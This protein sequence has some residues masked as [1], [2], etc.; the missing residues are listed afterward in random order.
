MKEEIQLRCK[1]ASC[2]RRREP[3][4]T[5]KACPSCG[6]PFADQ[7]GRTEYHLKWTDDDGKR[8]YES[9]PA[10]HKTL[11][12]ARKA[13]GR[14]IESLEDGTKSKAA[15]TR[16]S[17]LIEIYREEIVPGM[18]ANMKNVI[19]HLP[20]WKREIGHL[21]LSQVTRKVLIDA[22]DKIVSDG[23]YN[24][25][26]NR[27]RNS[28]SGVFRFA[29]RQDLLASNPFTGIK[30]ADENPDGG[31]VLDK[32]EV[33]ALLT[34]CKAHHHP[35]LYDAVV[36]ALS[37]GS[38]KANLIKLEWSAVDLNERRVALYKTKNGEDLHIPIFGQVLEVLQQRNGNREIGP[39]NEFVFPAIARHKN[40]LRFA[41]GQVRK[42]MDI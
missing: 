13:L 33:Q 23:P 21:K 17:T 19:A 1:S 29:M 2:N 27:Y 26:R 14:L 15:T 11:A 42:K 8:N 31:R 38:R 18:G 36:M 7:H 40:P 37:L 28:M 9:I 4:P 12:A 34:A 25:T 30:S 35:D 5:V 20:W 6:V 16:V 22:L 10:R 39:G 3:D 24:G 32:D 41:F